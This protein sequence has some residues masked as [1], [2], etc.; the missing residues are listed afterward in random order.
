M[1]HKV[2][3]FVC[4]LM[5]SVFLTIAVDSQNIVYPK[6]TRMTMRVK[7]D[8]PR[9]AA[10][11]SVLLDN[12]GG[13]SFSGKTRLEYNVNRKWKDVMEGKGRMKISNYKFKQSVTL[14]G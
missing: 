13:T 6:R 5:F 2:D 3:C 4:E 10:K 11:Y 9:F 7:A 1:T 14:S 12:K 8:G